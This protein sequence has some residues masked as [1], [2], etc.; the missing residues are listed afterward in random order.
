MA[1]SGKEEK[2]VRMSVKS[3]LIMIVL[4]LSFIRSS[5]ELMQV[6]CVCILL[7][8]LIQAS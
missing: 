3:L 7:M 6:A 8:M 1:E 2:A 4:A 5:S